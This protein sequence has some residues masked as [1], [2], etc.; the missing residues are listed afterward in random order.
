VLTGG[1]GGRAVK[2]AFADLF[3][4]GRLDAPA[5]AGRTDQ[6][7]FS[8]MVRRHDVTADAATYGRLREVYLMHLAREM[9]APNPDK[10][11]LPGVHL[12]L[13]ALSARA[14]VCLGLLTGNLAA[15][16]RIKLEHFDLWRYFGGG[17]FGDASLERTSLYYDAI[18]AV[19]RATGVTFAPRDTV[20]VGDTPL[21]VAVALD[22]GARSLAVATGGYGAEDLREAGADAVL[23]DLSDLT[24]VLTALG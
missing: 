4:L 17:G 6:W 10:R 12:L 22:T 5:V 24:Q 15:G 19:A 13:D 21:D 23:D 3:G 8:E 9:R 16:A 2:R 7:I 14:D 20:I 18:A 11:V 1:A